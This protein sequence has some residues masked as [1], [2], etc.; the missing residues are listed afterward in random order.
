MLFL[1]IRK[2]RD[3]KKKM[4]CLLWPWKCKFSFLAPSLLQQLMLVQCFCQVI[5]T[6]FKPIST[7]IF[8][9]LFSVI[10]KHLHYFDLRFS[11]G[12]PYIFDFDLLIG[13]KRLQE[14]MGKDSLYKFA[15]VSVLVIFQH[16]SDSKVRW[17]DLSYV[18][19]HWT[20]IVF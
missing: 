3:E 2:F 11:T 15:S 5:E 4:T 17:K 7:R 1:F 6:H 20:T 9:G 10:L 14:M 18:W 16:L 12:V 13:N 8:F 19:K